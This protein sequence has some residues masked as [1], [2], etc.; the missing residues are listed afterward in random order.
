MKKT[1]LLLAV[2]LCASF[3]MT[4]RDVYSRNIKSLPAAAQSAIEQ[5]F[6]AKVSIIEAEYRFGN[7]D[8]YEVTLTDGTEI[9]F[10]R[11]GNWK[12]V[13]VAPKK[14]V[15]SYFVP[16]TITDYIKEYNE[17]KRIVGI[18]KKRNTYEVELENG[19]EIIFDR[20]GR[21]VRYDD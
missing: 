2:M 21:F 15:P 8:E 1:M 17:G 13:D 19:I 9:I 12:E 20:A 6:K 10:D 5:N 11:S 14:K 3:A 16:K 18:E 4:A 7:I